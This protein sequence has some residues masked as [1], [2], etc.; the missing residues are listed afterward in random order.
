MIVPAR[1]GSEASALVL[2]RLEPDLF[3][4]ALEVCKKIPT[5]VEFLPGPVD[6]VAEDR[7]LRLGVQRLSQH[8]KRLDDT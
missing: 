5:A 8:R 7:E 3:L 6:G 4:L 1:S 2:R